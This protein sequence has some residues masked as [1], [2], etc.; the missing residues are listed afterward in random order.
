MLKIDI[1]S[2]GLHRGK[3]LVDALKINYSYGNGWLWGPLSFQLR[4]GERVQIAGN[5]GKG[6]TT[7][8]RIITGEAEP[9]QGQISRSD[10]QYL[11]LDQDYTI[12]D[13]GLS[14]FEQ[15]S[16]YN[17]RNL[18]EHQLRS[19][20]IYSQFPKHSWDRKSR[21]LSGG[22]KMKLSL[23]CLAVTTNTPDMLILDEPTN[24]L[25]VQSLEILTAAVK[26]YNGTL[27]VISHDEQF[28]K[29]IVMDK[30]I[31]L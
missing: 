16:H 12:I 19:L 25:D 22:E 29:D 4:S 1:H 15:V 3:L 5:N 23:C 28:I 30:A 14:V 27:V 26:T 31:R 8:I 24:N 20:L 18:E 6:K 7:L 13:G 10:F 17:S 2:S 21:D 11:H 9:M